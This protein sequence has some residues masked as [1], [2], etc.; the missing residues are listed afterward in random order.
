[1]DTV[2]QMVNRIKI[3][4]KLFRADNIKD[5]ST[6]GTGLG[7]YIIKIIVDNGGGQIW[8]KSEENKGTSFYFTVLLSGMK[9][10]VLKP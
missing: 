4:T 1:M 9:K 8:F 5:K 7:L 2:L 6:E 10:E 3:F